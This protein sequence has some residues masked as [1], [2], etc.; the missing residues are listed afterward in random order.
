MTGI[1]EKLGQRRVIRNQIED[2]VRRVNYV[3]RAEFVTMFHM[4][5]NNSHYR[6]VAINRMLE[7]LDD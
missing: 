5:L 6:E 3:H 4:L 1:P 7:I 2:M